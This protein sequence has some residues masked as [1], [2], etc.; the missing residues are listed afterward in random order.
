VVRRVEY[1]DKTGTWW[2]D[3]CEGLQFE[4][5]GNNT[6]VE[7]NITHAC[8]VLMGGRYPAKRQP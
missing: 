6:Q 1:Q 5:K 3:R 2:S 4:D 7:L 8:Y